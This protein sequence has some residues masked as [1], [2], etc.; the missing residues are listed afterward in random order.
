[1]KLKEKKEE[2]DFSISINNFPFM[3]RLKIEIIIVKKTYHKNCGN[4]LSF[5][6]EKPHTR[7]SQFSC[8]RRT[9]LRYSFKINSFIRTY[10]YVH[11]LYRL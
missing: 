1:M 10:M 8:K 5:T 9:Q 11:I 3:C 6:R 7:R 2:K 4:V